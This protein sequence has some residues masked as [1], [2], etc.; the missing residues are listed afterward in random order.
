MGS[1]CSSPRERPTERGGGCINTKTLSLHFTHKRQARDLKKDSNSQSSSSSHT[2]HDP[3]QQ[4]QLLN[5]ATLA[6]LGEH[7]PTGSIPGANATNQEFSTAHP[8]L[9]AAP[10]SLS[11]CR[12]WVNSVATARLDESSSMHHSQILEQLPV[13]TVAQ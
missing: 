6:V 3:Q 7:Q 2:L 11:A 13:P 12:D 8:Q 9:S 5:A 1:A 4:P 10:S